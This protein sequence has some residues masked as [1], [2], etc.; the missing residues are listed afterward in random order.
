MGW[1]H[2]RLSAKSLVLLQLSA[3]FFQLRLTKKLKITQFD[4]DSQHL[5]GLNRQILFAPLS[6]VCLDHK[7]AVSL[8]QT[9]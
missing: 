6:S 3:N 4:R 2:L 1:L 5:C 7:G 9:E 8:C